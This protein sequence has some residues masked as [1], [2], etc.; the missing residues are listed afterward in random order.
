MENQRIYS[1]YKH[2][3]LING[4]VYIGL[5]SQSPQQRWKHGNGYI[6]NS[7]FW[8]AIQKYGWD[9]GFKHEVLFSGLTKEEAEQKEIELIAEYDST[10][11]DKG[12]NI[13]AGGG[14]SN[15]TPEEK[16]RMAASIAEKKKGNQCGGKPVKCIE[17]GEVFTSYSVAARSVGLKTGAS[18]SSAAKRGGTAGGFHWELLE[19]P[20]KDYAPTY[21][22][23]VYNRF[24]EAFPDVKK[25]DVIET[26]EFKAA[27]YQPNSLARV[28][29][30][31]IVENFAW[32]KYRVLVD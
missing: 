19:K 2:T 32:G 9:E 31:N 24:K 13:L 10:N 11:R 22:E 1:V 20:K 16:K 15:A 5:T 21:Y 25:G 17:T 23:K 7:H 8:A 30:H 28:K 27:G 6:H 29:K 3:N 4:K 26:K 18:I 14:A 12:Y